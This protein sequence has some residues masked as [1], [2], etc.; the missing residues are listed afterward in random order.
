MKQKLWDLKARHPFAFSM[1][2]TLVV[3]LN[4]YLLI[5]ISPILSPI[6]NA[7]RII[8]PPLIAS[9]IGFY[10]LNPFVDFLHEKGL[11]RVLSTV[12]VSLALVLLITLAIFFI[13]PVVNEQISAI[14]EVM[15]AYWEEG[16][17]FIQQEISSDTIPELLDLIQRS[18]IMQTISRQA[19]N[20]FQAAI[21]GIGS[22][23]STTSQVVITIFTVPFVL[24]FMLV[25]S[26]KISG[27]IIKVTPVKFRPLMRRFIDNVDSQLGVYVRGQ[28]FV[29][30]C[31]GLIFL[32]GYA[33]IGLDFYL[34]LALIAA[35]FNLVPYLGSFLS[36]LLAVIVALFQDP[37]LVFYLAIVFAVEQ[38][39]ENR[40]IQPLVL[41]SQLNI[42]PI[43][44]LFVLLISGSTFGVVGLLLGVP[45]YAILKIIVTMAFEYIQDH[46][47]L[48]D[49]GNISEPEDAVLKSGEE[50]N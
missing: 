33:T 39:L 13:A 9:I 26:G 8:F 31:V 50:K 46:T 16:T 45:T 43:T 35:I 20:L 24:Y 21:G 29:A 28:V 14:V 17:Q 27:G 32:V 10:L 23:I 34:V 47:D 44:I 12:I 2:V 19:Q 30:I 5:Q 3:L 36:G 6:F 7:L 18:N 15:P 48:Y 1:L 40:M 42:H 37:I 49:E 11:S 38:I 4:I 22:V 41:G 25:D